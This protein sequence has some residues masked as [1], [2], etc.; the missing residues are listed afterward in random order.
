MRNVSGYVKADPYNALAETGA[1]TTGRETPEGSVGIKVSA[2]VA[3]QGD[4][5]HRRVVVE[6][7]LRAITYVA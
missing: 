2:F 4:V 1:L 3:V 7:P 6:C 5:E